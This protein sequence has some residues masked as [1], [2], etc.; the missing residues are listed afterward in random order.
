MARGG[1]PQGPLRFIWHVRRV[2][3]HSFSALPG[4]PAVQAPSCPAF[5]ILRATRPP[6]L[7]PRTPLPA[8]LLPH[9][10]LCRESPTQLLENQANHLY[11][12]ETTIR[13]FP[14]LPQNPTPNSQTPELAPPLLPHLA[15]H[16][17]HFQPPAPAP[18]LLFPGAFFL[19]CARTPASPTRSRCQQRTPPTRW[20]TSATRM[21]AR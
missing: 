15:D 21:L 3:A 12:R 13:N 14:S 8:T 4:G 17:Q 20:P 16:P 1:Q 18:Q 10:I 9:N 6:P 11:R 5:N 7:P 19:Q 2:A